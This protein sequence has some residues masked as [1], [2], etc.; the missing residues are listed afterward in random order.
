MTSIV[1]ET[2]TCP[3]CGTVFEA[4]CVTSCSVKGKDTDFRPHYVGMDA[5]PVFV[6]ACPRCHFAGYPKDFDKVCPEVRRSVL[7][8]KLKAEEVIGREP[9]EQLHG[10]TKYILAA[11]CRSADPEAQ[12]LE[13]ADL[14]LRASWCARVERFPERERHCQAEAAAHF[15]QA[16]DTGEAEANQ[17]P[18]ILY[19]IGE[20][21]RRLGMF[22]VARQYFDD[23]LHASPEQHEPGLTALIQ[24]QDEA[25]RAGRSENME[26]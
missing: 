7:S 23:A 19:L 3:V 1:P 21:Y 26:M 22:E 18:V 9:P 14:Y 17:R 16:L 8:G 4:W 20:L 6:Q 15:E 25:A 13:V 2:L 5:L 10:S 11:R 12:Q 24:R